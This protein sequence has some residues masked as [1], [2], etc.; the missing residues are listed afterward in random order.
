MVDWG[1][2]VGGMGG[3]LL[4][5]TDGSHIRTLLLTLFYRYFPEIISE[6]H[7]YIAQAPL[8][9][10][11]AKGKN[12][13][14][15]SE[16]EKDKIL[17]KLKGKTKK[18]DIQRYKGLGEMTPDQLW[19]TTMDPKNR[20]LLKVTVEDAAEADKIFTMLMGEEVEP[21]KRFIQTRAKE[22]KNLDI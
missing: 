14:A 21:R 3:F 10:I 1:N 6:G 20:T 4:H 19:Q 12:Y 11:R 18:I 9:K 17:A 8:Y 16:E 22:V 7:L 5:N 13:Y 2:F 15:Y